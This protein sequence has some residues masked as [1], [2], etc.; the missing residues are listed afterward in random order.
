MQIS[1]LK[2]SELLRLA[3]SHCR[4]WHTYLSHFSCYEKEVGLPAK[5]VLLYDLETLPNRGAF[6]GARWETDVI[7]IE[8]Y[9][10]I[11]CFA[12]Q[13]VGSKKIMF[14][15]W[16]EKE[17]VRN[18][19]RLFSESD[20]MVAH[21]NRAFD[22]KWSNVAFAKYGFPQVSPKV[23][24]TKLESKKRWYLPSY[25]LN[26]ISDYFGLGQKISH[27]GYSLWKKCEAGDKKARKQMELYNKRDLELLEKLYLKLK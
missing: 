19:Y 10:R 23:I 6:W 3:K 20:E 21:N 15:G 27:E 9:G 12:A 16:N 26:D 5:K 11:L 7:E 8:N 1:K 13:W 17:V 25:S 18:L 22:W 24:D 4:H 2:K 14:F